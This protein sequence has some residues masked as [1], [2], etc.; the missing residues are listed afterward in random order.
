MNNKFK[1]VNKNFKKKSRK[2]LGVAFPSDYIN[3][4]DLPPENVNANIF[5]PDMRI[6][7]RP[8]EGSDEI[9]FWELNPRNIPRWR[10]E[11]Q[12][13]KPGEFSAYAGH[14]MPTECELGVGAPPGVEDFILARDNPEHP[15]ANTRYGRKNW[16]KNYQNFRISP[17]EQ[18]AQW[19][20]LRL[21]GN[22]KNKPTG[23]TKSN[24]TRNRSI[25]NINRKKRTIKKR[26]RKKRTRK[27]ITRKKLE[28]KLE[29][30][31]K[32]EKKLEKN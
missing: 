22:R 25:C 10:G 1:K 15:L 4:S 28:K 16:W 9:P 23:I 32:L 18:E 11:G 17:E 21:L 8:D 19:A 7:S 3:S 13:A 27:K 14:H 20:A 31:E 5:G 24:R 30:L 12:I 29:K 2:R 26:T 6:L